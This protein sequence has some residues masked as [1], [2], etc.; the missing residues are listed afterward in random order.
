MTRAKLATEARAKRVNDADARVPS[1]DMVALM[2]LCACA[3]V[4]TRSRIYFDAAR[5][6]SCRSTT[7]VATRTKRPA[8]LREGSRERRVPHGI[9]IH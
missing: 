3:N 8:Q 7:D 9:T 5:W 1:R 2:R 6:T 4:F